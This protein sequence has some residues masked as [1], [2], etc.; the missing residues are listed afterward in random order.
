[1]QRDAGI[2]QC[3]DTFWE[4]P[5]VEDDECMGACRARFPQRLHE[6]ELGAAV[7]RQILHQDRPLALFEIALDPGVAAKAL[8]LLADV[9]HGQ[10]ELVG[11]PGGKGNAGG[12]A[13]GDHI[14]RLNADPLFD[15]YAREVHQDLPCGGK[16]DQPPAIHIDRARLAAGEGKRLIGSNENGFRLKQNS[17]GNLGRARGENWVGAWRRGRILGH[18]W[19]FVAIAN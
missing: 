12:L 19:P 8:G 14:E 18:G 7:G 4:N 16:S 15:Q 10:R 13:A 6:I 17:S 3:G 11:D 1:M 9:A 5:V 2:A